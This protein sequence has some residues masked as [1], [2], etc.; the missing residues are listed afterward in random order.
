MMKKLF[1]FATA[2]LILVLQVSAP[3]QASGEDADT[4]PG[5]RGA[6]D[7]SM[8]A[9][10]PTAGAP[11]IA[12]AAPDAGDAS[13]WAREGINAAVAKGFVPEEVQGNY[14][15]V[16]TRAGFCRMAVKWVEYATAKNI[17]AM[18]SEKG[19]SRDPGAFTDTRDP[20][21]LAAYALKITSGTGGGMFSPGGRIDREQAA[22]M[23]MNACS[24]VNA[25]VSRRPASG[26][27]DMGSASG[28]AVDGINYVRA[29]GIMQGTGDNAFSPKTAFTKEQSIVTFNNI[30]L[31][32]IGIINAGRITAVSAGDGHTMALDDIGQLWVWGDNYLPVF[33][34]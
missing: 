19:L 14:T 11:H 25:D 17:D 4:V 29:N 34:K 2:L 3:V 21:I 31:D 22:T 26:F 33:K 13:P 7:N 16:I 24:A 27:A 8:L 32:T 30:G 10:S 12:A 15:D 5:L 9:A 20:D 23:I 6:L 1:F 18:L 28:W